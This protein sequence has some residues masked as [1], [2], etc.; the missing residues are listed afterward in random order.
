VDS[1]GLLNLK[2]TTRMI[3]SNIKVKST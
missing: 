1:G 2:K 3:K